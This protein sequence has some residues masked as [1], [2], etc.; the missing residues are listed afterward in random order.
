MGRVMG[1]WEGRGILL[2]FIEPAP[3]TVLGDYIVLFHPFASHGADTP[4]GLRAAP[5]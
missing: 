3:I 2:A 1:Q 4:R 5:I